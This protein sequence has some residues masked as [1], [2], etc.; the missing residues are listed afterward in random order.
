MLFAF[1]ALFNL[2]WFTLQL[3]FKLVR[4]EFASIDSIYCNEQ[5]LLRTLHLYF[6][7]PKLN[8]FGK[9]FPDS[10]LLSMTP[11]YCMRYGN[12][13]EKVLGYMIMAFIRKGIRSFTLI[14]SVFCQPKNDLYSNFFSFIMY[15]HFSYF[16]TSD[17]KI[18]NKSCDF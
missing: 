18:F 3:S 2:N 12:C 11:I 9:K 5:Y 14:E 6:Y 7:F 10:P 1:W 17:K 15:N 4:V 13:N 16:Q 8:I